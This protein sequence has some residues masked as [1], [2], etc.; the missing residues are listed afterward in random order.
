MRAGKSVLMHFDTASDLLQGINTLQRYKIP[1]CEVYTPEHIYGLETKLRIKP[2]RLGHAFIKFGFLGGTALTTLVYYFLKYCELDKSVR[3]VTPGLLLN[4]L[5]M[6]ITFF[7]ALRLF[8]GHLPRV[9]Y[10]GPDDRRFLIVVKAN[11]INRSED[12]VNLFKYSEAVEISQDI[13]NMLAS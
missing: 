8:P 5:V 11:H 6:L 12:I 4:L 10:L 3:A 9:V 1:V 2:A 7:F 13:K